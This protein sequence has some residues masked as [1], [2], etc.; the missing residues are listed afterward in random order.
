M[1]ILITRPQSFCTRT[2]QIVLAVEG[3]SRPRQPP[4]RHAGW[5]IY[6]INISRISQPCITTLQ[7]ADALPM[8]GIL[9]DQPFASATILAM[10]I[11]VAVTRFECEINSST[12]GWVD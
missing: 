6:P 11:L 2:S 5:Q 8:D 10:D 7:L 12:L 4:E 1:R 3:K 9:G